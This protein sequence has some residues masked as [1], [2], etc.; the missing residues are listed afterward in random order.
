[1]LPRQIRLVLLSTAVV[2]A[3]IMTAL[4]A[5]AQSGYG[6]VQKEKAA[7]S[8][9]RTQGG[10]VPLRVGLVISDEVRSYRT[11]YMLSHIDFGKHLATQAQL[12]F[13]QS[14]AAVRPMRE[15]PADAH[16]S[17][18]LD[19]LIAIEAPDG[20]A[21]QSGLMSG[22]VTLVVRFTVRDASGTQLFQLQE[23]GSDKGSNTNNMLDRLGEAIARKFVQDFELDP[24]V[25]NLLSPAPAVEAKAVLADTSIMDSAG[26]DVPPPPPWGR[27]APASAGVPAAPG[28]GGR[29]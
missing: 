11:S 20:S 19:L 25:R 27:P 10:S 3:A 14:F 24:H 2:T 26:L 22:T 13:D 12:V 6:G 23:S 17:E 8:G 18:G 4:P 28:N 16:A 21:H 5:S 15:L 7:A 1:M 9:Q 29:P